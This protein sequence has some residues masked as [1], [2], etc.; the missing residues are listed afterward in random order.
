MNT[1][2][3][4]SLIF[5]LEQ[6]NYN[7]CLSETSIPL[8]Q[9]IKNIATR[10]AQLETE[11]EQLEAENK[12][13][14]AENQQLKHDSNN[15][16]QFDCQDCSSQAVQVALNITQGQLDTRISC[17]ENH[18]LKLAINSMADQL[19]L[20]T[21]DVSKVAHETAVEGKLGVQIECSGS[22]K[23]VWRKFI[24][25]LNSMTQSHLEQVRDISDVST[26][27]A[28]GDLSKTMTVPALNHNFET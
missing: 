28:R 22:T 3:I 2:E 24:L 17:P 6:G 20:L 15:N 27:I 18:P 26:A 21:R 13:L 9:V 7:Y 4:E 25:N 1:Q 11:N 14:E 8:H 16:P 23:G 10:Q 12:Q 19:Q 5:E